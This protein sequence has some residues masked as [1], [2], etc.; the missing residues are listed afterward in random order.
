MSTVTKNIKQLYDE[1]QN[2][3]ITQRTITIFEIL[4][5]MGWSTKKLIDRMTANGVKSTELGI[6]MAVSLNRTNPKH[7]SKIDQQVRE[8]T[9]EIGYQMII[10]Y[11]NLEK[12]NASSTD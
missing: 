10:D 9:I 8:R 5:Q 2:F 3:L 4:L 6:A 12:D 1:D 7:L 11:E